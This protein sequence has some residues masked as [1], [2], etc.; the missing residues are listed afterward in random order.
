MTK[1]SKV[2]DK[3]IKSSFNF[4]FF[5]F[6]ND[7]GID[8]GTT[9]TRI[10]VHPQ[11]IVLDEPSVVAINKKTGRVVAVGE[12]A[13]DMLGRTPSHI[14]AVRPLVEGV[15]SDYEIAEEMLTHFMRKAREHTSGFVP[16]RVLIGVPSGIT[17]VERRAVRDAAKN[18]GARSVYIVEELMAA[19]VGIGLPVLESSGVMVVDIGGG[20]T[21]IA[22]VT[23]GGVV[24][25]KNFRIAGGHLNTDI[26]RHIKE[27]Y[28]VQIGEK[29]AESLKIELCSLVDESKPIKATARG[30]DLVTGLPTEIEV[31]D[32]DIKEAV[33]LSLEKL[34]ETIKNVIE[35][36]P[37]EVM[38]DI[39]K[40][41][42]YLVGGGALIRGIDNV[43]SS[44]MKVP[45]YIADDPLTAVARGT[46]I[47][48]NELNKYKEVLMQNDD[49][50]PTE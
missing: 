15:I 47:M 44:F 8:L 27:V 50:I 18:A 46:G 24:K 42:V 36:M 32:K 2:N 12:R 11:G 22:V 26:I 28:K 16:P 37:P 33:V 35:S 21:D 49:E 38:S 1:R 10:Y 17:N 23:L 41:G 9:N 29:T 4:S 3:K 48:L 7:I 6:R 5:S 40:R 20:T 43:L 25:S 45:F 13:Q 14:E 34:I 19:A 31:T 30:R 39:M